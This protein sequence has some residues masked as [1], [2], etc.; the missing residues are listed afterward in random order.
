MGAHYA[1]KNRDLGCEG[2]NHKR[3]DDRGVIVAHLVVHEKQEEQMDQVLGAILSD[4]GPYPHY[5][6]K[7]HWLFAYLRIIVNTEGVEHSRQHHV[8]S[9]KA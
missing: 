3:H 4:Q 8:F 7:W 9:D 1:I 5:P 6:A 2:R